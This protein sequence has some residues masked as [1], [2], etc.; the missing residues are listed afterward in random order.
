MKFH[1]IWAYRV[2]GFN[3]FEKNQNVTDVIVRVYPVSSHK[4]HSYDLFQRFIW[5]SQ[6]MKDHSELC[7][8]G[9]LYSLLVTVCSSEWSLYDMRWE[10][11]LYLHVSDMLMW[12][13][14]LQGL[15]MIV[16]TLSLKKFSNTIWIS[17]E[18]PGNVNLFSSLFWLIV[19]ELRIRNSLASSIVSRNY[20]T[21]FSDSKFSIQDNSV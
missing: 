19:I 15:W 20:D 7:V 21:H 16:A 10:E 4:E 6:V 1:S 5:L 18:F 12:C 14:M 13:K 3:N 11:K 2:P 17:F 9:L 8:T